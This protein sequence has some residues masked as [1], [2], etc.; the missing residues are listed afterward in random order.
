[1]LKVLI[2]DDDIYAYTN[3]KE[4]IQWEK[5]GF[6]LCTAVTNGTEAIDIIH[7]EAPGIVITDMSMPG[8]NGIALI[9]F[10]QDKYPHI[11]VIALS[12][13]DDFEYVKQSLKMGAADYILK[14][15]LTAESLLNILQSLREKIVDKK[16]KEEVDLKIEEQIQTGKSVLR[17]K[18][19]NTL[20]RGGVQE[21]AEIER[22]VADLKLDLGLKNLVIVASA[23]DDYAILKEKYTAQELN[24]LMESMVDMS[25][26]I[27]KDSNKSLISIIEEEKFVIVFSFE[28]LHSNQTIF[29][30]VFTTLMRIKATMKRYLNITACFGMD[31]ICNDIVNA[32]QYYCRAEKLLV[33]KFYEGKDRIFHD[34]SV[35]E[36]DHNVSVLEIKDEKNILQSIKSLERDKLKY[37]V[38][39]VFEKIRQYQPGL[40]STK[41]AFITLINI[42]N[43]VARDSGIDNAVIYDNISDP[44]DQLK[45]FDTV[46]EVKDWLMTVYERLINSLELF[47]INPEYDEVTKKAIEYIYR[48]YHNDLSLGD[49]ADYIGVNSSYLSRK[50]KKDC[51]KG[52]VEYLN[53]VRIE[54]AKSLMEN[55]CK[56]VKEI[57]LDVGFYNYNYFF[58]VFKDSQGMT[59]LEYEKSCRG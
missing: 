49:I 46:A 43:K 17:Q 21:K 40:S 52:V 22:K 37:Y 2:V 28:D 55:G 20:M 11:Q 42:A 7:K 36:A 10:I 1:M 6:V 26:E 32:G 33:K 54:Q 9:K 8:M 51:G 44:Y 31:G 18:F 34:L 23:V 41:M 30:Q 35:K 13:Y 58:K 47:C 14:H 12:A 5:E 19:I 45:K 3:L 15:T 57:A 39:H 56:K 24:N 38:N 27:L 53:I 29:N 4:L 50:F 59:P 16:R 48:N 25:T